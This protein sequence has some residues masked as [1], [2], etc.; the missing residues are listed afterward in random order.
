MTERSD[1]PIVELKRRLAEAEKAGLAF[2]ANRLRWQLK[3][4][5]DD[6]ELRRLEGK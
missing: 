6:A 2:V 3:T 5:V 1:F 4:A